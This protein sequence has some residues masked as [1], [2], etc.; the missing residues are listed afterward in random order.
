VAEVITSIY[1][2][3]NNKCIGYKTV[4]MFHYS[5]VIEPLR[6]LQYSVDIE[7]QIYIAAL[8]LIHIFSLEQA[9]DRYTN[10]LLFFSGVP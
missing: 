4:K 8:M 5:A 9:L 7:P 2:T 10:G 6:Q 3:W 1:L